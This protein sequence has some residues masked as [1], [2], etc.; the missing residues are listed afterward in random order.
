MYK[1]KQEDSCTSTRHTSV[2]NALPAHLLE[3]KQ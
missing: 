2:W 1:V 3:D